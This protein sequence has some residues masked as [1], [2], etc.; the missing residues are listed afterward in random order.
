MG[1]GSGSAIMGTVIEA[2]ADHVPEH[3]RRVRIYKKIIPEFQ[4]YDWDTETECMG[5]DKAYDEALREL[6]PDW[7]E[8][9]EENSG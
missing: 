3:G 6:H 5:E 7:F 4:N 1:W 9:E 8:E 2:L